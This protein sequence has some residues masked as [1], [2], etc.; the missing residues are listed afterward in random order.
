MA[1]HKKDIQTLGEEIA[2]AITHGIGTALAVSGL[3]LLVA[4]AIAIQDRWRIVAVSIY[5]S[6]LVFLY[7]ASTLYHSFQFKP[8][9][10]FFHIMDH[11]GIFFLIA[12]TYTPFL[13]IKMRDTTGWVILIALWT[14]AI[15]G[16]SIKAFFTGRYTR[17]SSVI[18]IL[19]GWAAIFKFDA[20]VTAVDP[21][22]LWLVI[23]GGLSYT[24]GVIP[25]LM[26]KVPYHHAI[27]H[28]FV[29]G[30]SVCHF[31]AIF[32]YILPT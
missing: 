14:L 28:L 17:I 26:H 5:G 27:W 21:G 2:N 1:E 8:V 29:I 19:M 24:I 25:F 10:R 23:A 6:T 9:K 11:I 13:L 20:F 3:T 4:T 16:A 30:G 18:Y 32:R 15:V 31:L 7:L 12:G 22:A